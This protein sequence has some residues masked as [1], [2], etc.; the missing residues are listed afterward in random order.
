MKSPGLSQIISD[1]IVCGGAISFARF[2]ELALY[3]P[4]YGYYASGHASVGR[5]GDFYT[6][7]S[8]GPVFGEVLAGQILE[9]WRALGMPDDFTIVEQGAN[10]GQLACDVLD[11]LAGTPLSDVHF[12]I[13]EPFSVL[14]AIQASKLD[15]RGVRWVEGADDLPSFCGVHFSN[16]LFDAFPVHVVRSNGNSWNELHVALAAEEFVWKA[17]LPGPDV[18]EALAAYPCRPAGYTTEVRLSHRTLLDALASKLTSGFVLAIDYGMTAEN[19][20]APH[21]CDG[22]LSCYLAHR[23]DGNPL[24]LPGEKDITAHVDFTALAH[25]ALRAGLALEGFADQHHF[26]V[27]ASSSMLREMDGNGCIPEPSIQKKLL[28]LRTLLHPESM[29]TQ[30]HVILFSKE[31]DAGGEMSGFQFARDPSSLLRKDL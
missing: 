29:G 25:D 14:R 19:L 9:M 16:E 6:S 4:E 30:F 2:M 5:A 27:G 11:A 21:R 20:L 28:Q 10:D 31:A 1:E 24:A 12:V 17:L 8:V 13:V 22:T 3:A 26:L 18:A 15:G 23:R 7:V